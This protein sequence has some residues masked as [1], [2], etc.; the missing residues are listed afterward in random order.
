[1]RQLVIHPI[2]SKQWETLKNLEE[3]ATFYDY[4]KK[5]DKMMI[6]FGQSLMNEQMKG[7]GTDRRKKKVKTRY[8]GINLSKT[9]KS[10]HVLKNKKK[11][12]T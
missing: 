10:G 7:K 11:S 4:E 6:D 2:A 5:F 1:M 8:G 3:E 9:F 12:L